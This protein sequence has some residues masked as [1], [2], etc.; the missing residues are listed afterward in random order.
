MFDSRPR[1]GR[2]CGHLGKLG[3]RS[4]IN[5]NFNEFEI[6]SILSAQSIRSIQGL[7]EP[8][9]ERTIIYGMSFGL[10]C[11]GYDVRIAQS[12][13]ISSNK[14]LLASTIERFQI[15]NNILAQVTDKSSWA[16]QGLSLFNT[17]LE[18]SWNGYLTLEL[19]NHGQDR[20]IIEKG[21]PIAQII[22]FW[23]D[24]PTEQEY[25]GKYNNQPDYPVRAILEP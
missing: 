16:R 4:C 1:G 19:A 2:P 25:K 24:E 14:F 8:F 23:L 12:V 17:I 9:C 11:S 10:S 7:I 3:G 6:M 20:L 22:F 13:D 15:P 21:M 18:P 5:F